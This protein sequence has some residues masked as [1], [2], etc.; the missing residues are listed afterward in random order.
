MRKKT[1]IHKIQDTLI[2]FERVVA[3]V[4]KYDQV[5]SPHY[6]TIRFYIELMNHPIDIII[7]ASD[8]KRP[9]VL[10]KKEGCLVA[11]HTPNKNLFD[12]ELIRIKRLWEDAK[13]N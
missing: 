11:D 9:A 2:D 6:I 7:W 10:N 5:S 1:H 8:L 12:L 13:S 3:L 4:G